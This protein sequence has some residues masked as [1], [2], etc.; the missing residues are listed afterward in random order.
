[1]STAS[2]QAF[3]DL[4]P[5]L[6]KRRRAVYDCIKNSAIGMTIKD[7]EF[8]LRWPANCI[9]GRLTELEEAGL[10]K[11]KEEKRDGMSIYIL[12]D[13]RPI[14]KRNKKRAKGTVVHR[15][16]DPELQRT[17]L[18]VELDALETSPNGGCRVK[19]SW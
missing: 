10:I 19:V 8:A 13:G 11:R 3:L 4:E 7:L 9:S 14:G 1:M 6:P 18:E 5:K 17:I 15:R 16:F 2:M 12:G